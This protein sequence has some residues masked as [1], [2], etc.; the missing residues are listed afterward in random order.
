VRS[1]TPYSVAQSVH[2]AKRRFPSSHKHRKL[3]KQKSDKPR[4]KKT[5]KRKQQQQEQYPKRK[6][7]KNAETIK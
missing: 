4:K 5:K 6:E 1:E 7:P 2:V 3:E